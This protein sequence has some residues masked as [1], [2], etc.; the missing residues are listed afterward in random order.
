MNIPQAYAPH[1]GV[2]PIE[3]GNTRGRLAVVAAGTPLQVT[4]AEGWWQVYAL[5]GDST[6]NVT[7][8]AQAPG[9]AAPLFGAMV[10]LPSTLTD[11]VVSFRGDVVQR[12]Y[13]PAGLP[14]LTLATDSAGSVQ[15]SIVQIFANS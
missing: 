13:L 6:L 8:Q 12:I 9:A 1:V 4:L 14:V 2:A 10:P 7:L 3:F 5:R 15:V 11:N